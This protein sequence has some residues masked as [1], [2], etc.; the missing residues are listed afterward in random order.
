[1]VRG[2]VRL[3]LM[4]GPAVLAPVPKSVLDALTSVQ[5]TT[6]SGRPS[7]F[8]L[9]FK[10]GHDSPLHTLFLVS[11]G[12]PLQL[13]R[14]LIIAT[15]NG[16]SEVL[17]DGLMR[18]HEVAPGAEPGQSTLTVSGDD[19]TAAMDLVEFTGIPYPAMSPS[20]R[21]ALI[22]AKYAMFGIVPQVI[23]S[24]LMEVPNPLELIPRHKGSDLEYINFLADRVGYVFYI[25]PGPEP[26]M[27]VAYWG[28]E[29][30]VGRPQLALSLDM[31]VHTNVE[32]L[33]F[34][35]DSRAKTLPVIY[36]HDQ[37]TKAPIS[38]PLP[39]VNPLSPPLGL[40]PAIPRRVRYITGT[41][42]LSPTQAIIVGLAKAAQTADVVT[43]SGSLDVLRY[44]RVLK[45]R[46]LVGVR[47]AGL[48][49]DGLYY[50]RSVTHTIRRGEYRQDFTLTRNGLLSTVSEVPV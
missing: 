12:L 46:Q 2:P 29:L 41:A 48:A 10:L 22:L 32:S 1:M 6:A 42:K 23:P 15:I 25:D 44:G 40:V 18:Q 17:M 50:V 30:K 45:A 35:Y 7:G 8:Q 38:I 49:F 31:G 20:A 11:A 27:S 39:D 16:T 47:G 3:T 4:V 37:T 33:N 43:G 24:V 9:T 28:P 26:G 34:R 14:V 36:I 19:L 5:V 21:V 13:L